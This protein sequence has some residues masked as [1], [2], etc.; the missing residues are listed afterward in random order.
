MD[1]PGVP[2]VGQERLWDAEGRDGKVY[3]PTAGNLGDSDWC[4]GSRIHIWNIADTSRIHAANTLI[5]TTDPEVWCSSVGYHG[6]GGKWANGVALDYYGLEGRRTTYGSLGHEFH[7]NGCFR[8]I[9]STRGDLKTF[10]G[11]SS[12]S[13]T[14]NAAKVFANSD[15]SGGI[16]V[17]QVNGAGYQFLIQNVRTLDLSNERRH[18]GGQDGDFVDGLYQLSS[19]GR[20]FGWGVP[21]VSGFSG[22]AEIQPRMAEYI[23]YMTSSN[24]TNPPQT[25]DASAAFYNQG[26]SPQFP[27]PPIGME[28]Q[29]YM[30]HWLDETAANTFQNAKHLSEDKVN[31]VSIYRSVQD[32]YKGG[33]G[34]D[35]SPDSTTFGAG[36]RSLNLFDLERLL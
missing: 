27:I 1:N 21:A 12:F 28:W 30:R 9:F 31:G 17:D 32:T 5:N 29:G 10:Y 35:G 13:G 34:R 25:L 4:L 15:T 33:E 11:V 24:M 8:L 14:D 19:C 2:L 18:I 20:V 6:P 7:N 3:T 22:V 16:P 36:V 26:M 23:A